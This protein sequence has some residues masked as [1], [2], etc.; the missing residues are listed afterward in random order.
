MKKAQLTIFIII[1]LLLL[2]S[3]G[4][5]IYFTTQQIT[6]P[7]EEEVI[8]PEDVRPVYEFVQACADDIARE[9]LG[10]LG[11]QGGFIRLPGI[12]ER[13]P[14]AYV[15]L[16]TL[17]AFKVPL[18]YYEG[19]DRTPSIGYMER[20]ISRHVN[21]RLRECAEGFQTFQGRMSVAEEGNVTTRTTI[22]DD[23]VIL[24]ISWPLALT[25]ADRTTRISEF[26]VRLPVKL[27]Q[28]WELANATMGYENIATPFENLT[29]DLMA[30][31]SEH[32]PLDGFTIE[33]GTKTWR[34][35]AI[36]DR[37]ERL[38]YYNIPQTRIKGTQH[39]PFSASTGTY[40]ALRR[41]HARM[42]RELEQ[43]KT[44]AAPK[45]QAPDD[46]FHYFKTFLDVGARE[47][48]LKAGFEFQPAWGMQF[49]AQPNDGPV[50]KS[51]SGKGAG[52]FLRFLCINQ[53]HFTYD[54]IYPIK[55][56]IRDDNA[57]GGEGYLFQFAFPVLIDDNAPA[58]EAF[59]L[60]AFQSVDFG[61]P[62]FCTTYGDKTADI[63]A[64]GPVP[65]GVQ[66]ELADA[67]IT[68]KCLTEECELG[69][70]SAEGGI[71]RLLTPLPRGCTN[72]FI[73]AA[74]D[75][76]LPETAQLTSDRLDL[77]LTPLQD[78][79]LKFEVYPYH[80][81]TNTWGDPRPPKP[82]ERISVQVSMVNRTFDTTTLTQYC[83][84]A[85][86]R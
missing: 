27:K 1:G 14:S 79:Q 7:I 38:L 50:L 33:C 12:I 72:P 37:V 9:G 78:L 3:V 82:E 18:W 2:L 16:D 31:D 58:R 19:E 25:A 83:S 44:P 67:R 65:G 61:A 36:H 73:T 85:T 76:Y 43:G 11:L 42:I 22:A 10:I 63:R 34:L 21:E 86:T 17:G 64:F 24:R 8:M 84:C 13:T 46:A 45:T 20:E 75:G 68:Y 55:V 49:S 23:Q 48:D 40:E 26:V 54:I 28:M 32:V 80:G 81:Q 69:T 57:F 41:E 56:S 4:L 53:W 71:Y 30:A 62:E 29:I 35:P 77:A 51:N 70:T 74:K 59:G 15:P 52:K 5:V 66:L 6:K 60:K 39:A 47:S